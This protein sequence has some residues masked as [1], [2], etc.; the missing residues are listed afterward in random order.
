VAGVPWW[1]ALL[2]AIGAT[3]IGYG[4]D[5]GH[6]EL[7]H[8]F[9]TC[10]IAGCVIAVLA[11]RQSGV[12]TAVIQPPLILF[13]AVPGAYWLFHGGKI[14]KL[15]DL[16]INC[17]YPLIERFPLMLGT[18]GVVLLIGLIR[19]YVGMTHRPD[20]DADAKADVA[21]TESKSLLS[22][23]AA[24]FASLLAGTDDDEHET[25]STRPRT[26][27]RSARTST[28]TGRAARG[29]RAGQR[30]DRSRSRH[31]R[32]G[33]EDQN[34]PTAERRQRRRAQQRPQ[35][36]DAAD[37][38]RRSRRPRPQGEP[39]APDRRSQR[40]REGRRDSYGRRGSIERP[41]R[42]RFDPYESYE[43]PSE[44]FSRYEKPYDRYDSYEQPR[45][46]ATPPA[47]EGA[48]PTHHPISQVRYRG[49]APRDERPDD[50][51]A[52]RRGRPRAPR[53]PQA[54]SWEYDF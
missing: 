39:D 41:P 44:Q 36:L 22:G 45:R 21:P 17:G 50:P 54:E 35:D 51:R 20:A 28:R 27:R 31:S 26:A 14:D 43:P 53:R 7:T 42:S 25:D 3:V 19:W 46:R 10:Y 47:R 32:A 9:A 11:V 4:I 8:V 38:P 15:K 49:S 1:A 37:P 24:K 12:F 48:S 13:C 52:E 5:A 23:I 34:D 2:I 30:P 29:T 6:K 40:S 33:L 18:A 16:L